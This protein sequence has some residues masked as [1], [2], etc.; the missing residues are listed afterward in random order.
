MHAL[1]QAGMRFNSE[2]RLQLTTERVNVRS[3]LG[4]AMVYTI[5]SRTFLISYL[6][7]LCDLDGILDKEMSVL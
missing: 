7:L 2:L 4:Y 3:V 5:C 6:S 1:M